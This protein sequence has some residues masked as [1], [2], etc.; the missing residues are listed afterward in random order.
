[1]VGKPW[2]PAQAA[3]RLRPFA[4]RR[5]IMARPFLVAMRERKPWVRLRLSTLGWKV[6]FIVRILEFAEPD[7]AAA[8]PRIKRPGILEKRHPKINRYRGWRGWYLSGG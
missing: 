4:R 2:A 5:L 6:L 3:R 7:R 8:G 1:M